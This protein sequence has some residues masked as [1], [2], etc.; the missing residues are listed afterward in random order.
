MSDSCV[1]KV[2]ESNPDWT[3]FEQIASLDL[4][5]FPFSSLCEKLVIASYTKNTAEGRKIDIEFVHE[6]LDERKK[7]RVEKPD[8]D[9]IKSVRMERIVPN[10]SID[11]P[12]EEA[13][14]LSVEEP[15]MIVNEMVARD[16]KLLLSSFVSALHILLYLASSFISSSQSFILS[17]FAGMALI[18][19]S[20]CKYRMQLTDFKVSFTVVGIFF[21]Y[22]YVGL[23]VTERL[24]SALSSMI[25]LTGTLL[26][27]FWFENDIPREENTIE[28]EQEVEKVEE[29]N[30]VSNLEAE[31]LKDESNQSELELTDELSDSSS[32]SDDQSSDLDEEEIDDD[33]NGLTT[34][35]DEDL[36]KVL[37]CEQ[38]IL[39]DIPCTL[40]VFVNSKQHFLFLIQVLVKT[41]SGEIILKSVEKSLRDFLQLHKQ[42]IKLKKTLHPLKIPTLPKRRKS[43]LVIEER[44]NQRRSILAN[45]LTRIIKSDLNDP[46]VW[47]LYASFLSS[48]NVC[49]NNSNPLGSR[50][51]SVSNSLQLLPLS[52][53]SLVALNGHHW[54]EFSINFES[55]KISICGV[56][57]IKNESF[58]I[59]FDEVASCG[60][61][62]EQVPFAGYNFLFIKLN[63]L[64][65]FYLA[66]KHDDVLIALEDKLTKCMKKRHNLATHSDDG[67][68]LNQAH[69]SVTES[70]SEFVALPKGIDINENGK[71]KKIILNNRVVPFHPITSDPCQFSI[72]I[73]SEFLT[74]YEQFTNNKCI[75]NE[76]LVKSLA[77]LSVKASDLA[78]IKGI[79]IM[80]DTEK[81]AFFINI[82]HVILLHASLEHGRPDSILKL[83]R[84]LILASY[85]IGG[86][87]YSLSEIEHCV[88]RGP[89][90]PPAFLKS[91]FIGHLFTSRFKTKDPRYNHAPIGHFDYRI[92]FVLNSGTQSSIYNIFVFDPEFL[93]AQLTHASKHFINEQLCLDLKN[94]RI[95]LPRICQWYMKDFDTSD[96]R[97][98]VRNIWHLLPKGFQRQIFSHLVD[99][100]STFGEPPSTSQLK[101]MKIKFK[102]Y[103]WSPRSVFF[104]GHE[105]KEKCMLV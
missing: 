54:K 47:P 25:G 7:S 75:M 78:A 24:S 14:T 9:L 98:F 67:L 40:E 66:H 44:I 2:H 84:F 81:I 36:K 68:D 10:L 31:A 82:Y 74:L 102:N 71:V 105:L 41:S 20:K 58:I 103:E 26:L 4:P 5:K 65:T 45:Y 30:V 29:K 64:Q 92:N 34:V 13:K 70:F 83:R 53:H 1:Y 35:I 39:I 63:S 11:L 33:L 15:K 90:N 50:P 6:V 94:N 12:T 99:E 48:S 87:V 89:S 91:T 96:K 59:Y 18:I 79:E 46:K 85:N 49:L 73:L 57:N 93:D 101:K 3:Y 97:T 95:Q 77:D 32:S 55:N 60:M 42:A 27:Y 86:Y 104:R 62:K 23:V 38:D 19:A 61:I 76:V 69:G 22:L 52:F 37:L 56:K 51:R 21:S 100:R 80:S 16:A 28:S 17:S 88:L 43:I 8:A 72:S